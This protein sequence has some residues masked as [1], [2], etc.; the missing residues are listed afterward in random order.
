MTTKTKDYDGFHFLPDPENDD[1]FLF[2]FFN[3]KRL[4]GNNHST[5]VNGGNDIGDLYNV[6]L[7]RESGN[8]V[9]VTDIFQAIFA[10]PKIYA[11]GLI[12]SDIYGT[13]VKNTEH[14]NEWWK[15]YVI[16][17]KR[18]VNEFNQSNLVGNKED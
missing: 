2:Q 7:M 16:T 3:L 13:F 1:T 4:E 12:G 18:I 10:D 9:E 14:A 15:D 17:T 5:E 8:S 11:E 6:L